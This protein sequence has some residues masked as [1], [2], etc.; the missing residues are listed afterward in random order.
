HVEEV[1]GQVP[2]VVG[3]LA[4]LAGVVAHGAP[5]VLQL[6]HGRGQPAGPDV[7]LDLAQA[8]RQLLRELGPA[9]AREE[10]VTLRLG[11]QGRCRLQRRT[12]CR[13]SSA[14]RRRGWRRRLRGWW[15]HRDRR[16]R[17]RARLVVERER[18]GGAVRQL[19]LHRAAAVAVA[20]GRTLQVRRPPQPAHGAD[21]EVQVLRGVDEVAHRGADPQLAAVKEGDGVRR[22]P[23]PLAHGRERIDHQ[24]PLTVPGD[25]GELVRRRGADLGAPRLLPAGGLQEAPLP[26]L[27]PLLDGGLPAR[28]LRGP[29]HRRRGGP[30]VGVGLGGAVPPASGGEQHRDEEEEE[31]P[32]SH[33]RHDSGRTFCSKAPRTLPGGS[34]WQT[35]TSESVHFATA[36]PRLVVFAQT[37]CVK[38]PVAGEKPGRL[39]LYSRAS[40][41]HMSTTDSGVRSPAVPEARFSPYLPWL[42]S[43]TQPRRA[44]DSAHDCALAASSFDQRSA[45]AQCLAR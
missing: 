6:L 7:V 9:A 21:E 4:H 12:W 26:G 36:Q 39:K 34:Y 28:G 29:D 5:H 14:R 42:W 30:G 23:V 15:R 19:S 24:Q 40:R 33:F 41:Y 31:T 2:L 3:Q 32:A 27:A 1:E 44:R 45:G 18:E 35:H 10:L 37:T 38:W 22:F 17:A 8:A 11:E 20:R 13:H 43:S 25:E 16:R